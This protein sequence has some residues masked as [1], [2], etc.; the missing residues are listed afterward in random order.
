[1]KSVKSKV[2]N[3]KHY[4]ALTSSISFHLIFILGASAL[5]MISLPEKTDEIKFQSQKK[6]AIIQVQIEKNPV[7]INK[8]IKP[9]DLVY[10]P[11]IKV[12]KMPEIQIPN[13]DLDMVD[14]NK[15]IEVVDETLFDEPKNELLLLSEEVMGSL[16][17][18]PELHSIY[19]PEPKYPSE[20]RNKQISGNVLVQF[21]VDQE[22]LPKKIKII[23]S[24]HLGFNSSVIDAIRKWKYEPIKEEVVLEY[25]FTFKLE[26]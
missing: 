10:I 18:S 21:T 12:I 11:V 4:I 9:L 24:S 25:P 7:D 3:K 17:L 15:V 19:Q 8:E 13:I 1:M 26:I 20:L 22:G 14:P 23:E 6:E 16:D 5:V 2:K